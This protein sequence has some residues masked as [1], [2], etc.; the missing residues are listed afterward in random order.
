VQD[1]IQAVVIFLVPFGDESLP[2]Y[3]LLPAALM[4]YLID[5]GVI[6][7]FG[8]RSAGKHPSSNATN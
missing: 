6:Y 1:V 8:A 5:E 7:L 2:A 4:I 3:G